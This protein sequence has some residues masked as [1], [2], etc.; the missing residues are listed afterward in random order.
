[1]TANQTNPGVLALFPVKFAGATPGVIVDP[2]PPA[3]VPV[4]G[5]ARAIF[6]QVVKRDG[7]R[8]G[9]V[10]AVVD[11]PLVD[12]LSIALY[13]TAPG[14]TEQQLIER[15]PVAPADQDKPVYFNVFQSLLNDGVHIFHYVV[16]RASGNSAPSTQSWALYHRDLP[17]GS[18]VPGTGDHPYLEISL[19][20]ELGNPPQIG[21]EEADQGVPLTVFYPFMNAYDVITLELNRERFTFTVQPG[22]E[23]KSYVI[24][25]TRAMFERAGNRQDFAISYTVVSQLNNPTDKR[26]WSRTIQADVDT[27]R[28]MLTA[29]DLIENP[30]DPNDDPDTID[31]GKVKDFLYVLVHVFSPLW[32]AGDIVRVKCTCTPVTG[33][34]VT[35]NAEEPVGRLPFTRKLTVPM[36]KVLAGGE[37]SALYEQVR[38]GKVIAVSTAAEAQV[39]GEGAIKLNPPTLVGTARPLDIMEPATLRVEFLQARAGDTARV[40]EINPIPGAT[41]FQAMAFNANKRTNTVLTPAFLAARQGRQLRFRWVLIRGGEEIAR[42]GP[43]VLMV[44]RIEDGDARLPLAEILQAKA[45]GLNLDEFGGDATFRLLPWAFIA[46]G[47]EINVTVVDRNHA[48]LPV[49]QNYRITEQDVTNGLTQAISRPWLD[50]LFDNAAITVEVELIVGGHTIAFKDVNYIVSLRSYAGY[51]DFDSS[52]PIGFNP[53]SVH[54]FASGITLK[55]LGGIVHL[56]NV[57]TSYPNYTSLLGRVTLGMLGTVEFTLPGLARHVT[58][59]FD[60]HQLHEENA[61]VFMDERGYV[62]GTRPLT[63]TNLYQYAYVSFSATG[64]SRIKSFTI[65]NIDDMYVDRIEVR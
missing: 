58:F 6:T 12:Y 61:V 54:T 31:L 39:I 32:V 38:E 23:G 24:V 47:Q 53:G 51:E 10:Q 40:V 35:H 57:H 59:L 49:L 8:E 18:N 9:A 28:V 25:I 56:T 17:G 41:P 42:S 22:Q 11:P 46:V 52:P 2:A 65:T 27:Q 44:K 55:S 43:L 3:G 33:S 45:G 1:M 60:S 16:E 4:E 20:P 15:K 21:K 30:D 26:R 63:Y 36:A 48:P 19:P 34:A 64:D 14:S 5:L 62:I 13:M 29:P 50:A 7:S 37:A